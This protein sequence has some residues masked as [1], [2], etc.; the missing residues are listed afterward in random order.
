MGIL[1]LIAVLSCIGFL[2]IA[3]AIIGLM[4]G[5]DEDKNKN[6]VFLL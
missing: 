4:T 2:L 6:T 1:I 3:F 5:F